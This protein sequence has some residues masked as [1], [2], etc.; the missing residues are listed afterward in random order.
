MQAGTGASVPGLSD[1]RPLAAPPARSGR[2]GDLGA[3]VASAAVLLAFALGALWQG[4]WAWTALA[5]LAGAVLA[6]EWAGLWLARAFAPSGL[7]LAAGL[8]SAPALLALDLALPAILV[9]LGL[10]ALGGAIA[11]CARR[12]AALAAGALA[13]G[14]GVLAL[15]WLRAD[16]AVGFVNLLFVLLVVWASDIGAYLAGRALGGP[17]LAPAISPGKTLSGALGGLAAAMAAGTALAAAAGTAPDASLWHAARLAVLLGM[18][19]QAGDLAE[20]WL[21]RRAGVKDSSRLIPGH[22]GLLDRLDALLVV[23]P[24]AAG[25]ALTLGPGV[26]LWQ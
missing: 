12:G 17:K 3:R 26:V 2:W 5:V 23:A 9:G 1:T 19:A 24:V 16:P 25:L 11:G 6:L 7:A 22:G 18:V 20:S 13:L 15:L 4:G 10:A 14:P 21:K 8:A